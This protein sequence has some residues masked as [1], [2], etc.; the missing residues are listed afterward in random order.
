MNGRHAL[1]LV[2]VLAVAGG[3]AALSSTPVKKVERPVVHEPMTFSNQDKGVEITK[4][5]TLSIGKLSISS[6]DGSDSVLKKYDD[7]YEIETGGYVNVRAF[8][9]SEVSVKSE[10]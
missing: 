1:L 5:W 3:V 4:P 10:K 7:R 9:S 6:V 2:L 8:K